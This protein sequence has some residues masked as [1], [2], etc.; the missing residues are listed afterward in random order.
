ME[1]D[2]RSTKFDQQIQALSTTTGAP[3]TG[4]SA[5]M[6]YDG[7]YDFAHLQ[8]TILAARERG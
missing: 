6:Y 2:G 5:T 8:A 1:A 4:K 7:T 3:T